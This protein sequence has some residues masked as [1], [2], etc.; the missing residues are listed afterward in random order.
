MDAVVRAIELD[1]LLLQLEGGSFQ[2]RL[3]TLK[4]PPL[5]F[6]WF[7]IRRPLH[8]TGTKPK[9]VITVTLDLDPHPG[10]A[11][12]RSHGLELPA[13]SLFGLD[14][15]GEVHFTIPANVSFAVLFL[16]LQAL[17]QWA[18]QLGWH[19]FDGELVPRGNVVRTNPRSS[20]ALRR[21]LRR[22]FALAEQR[23]DHLLSP[24]RQRLILADLIPLLLEALSSGPDANRRVLGSPA[25][26]QIVKDVQ[27]WVR[28]NP[29]S[30]I[31]LADLCR[32]AHASRR[33]L[34]QGFQDHLG[35]GPMAYVKL[36][37][38]HGI[39]RQLVL[40]DPGEIQISA[41]ADA[42]GFHNAGHFAADY[43]RLFGETPRDTLRR[44]RPRLS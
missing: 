9:G 8:V 36:L 41:L 44:A 39:R 34:L 18:Q 38:L 27:R 2:G 23:Q 43:R 37:R 31:S 7:Q 3:L 14:V 28:A 5:F 40:A 29:T 35:M 32:E 25:R 42:W 4:L 1:L 11:P 12:W 16:P 24:E 6:L 21:S 13:D 15:E 17:E 22:L 10:G 30:P 33:T 26:I 20:A 19:G